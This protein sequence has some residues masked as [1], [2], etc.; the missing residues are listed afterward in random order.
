MSATGY[1]DACGFNPVSG[2]T[3]DFVVSAAI[4]GYQTPASAGAVNST[5]YSY[6][7]QSS[8]LSQW[9]NGFGAY[10]TS[11]T[12]LARTTVTASSTGSKV[13]FTSPP[14]VYITA[15]SADLQNASLLASGVVLV[16][17]LPT[18]T[19]ANNIVKLDGSAK[20]PAVDG[21]ALTNIAI[22]GATNIGAYVLAWVVGGSTNMTPG[23]TTAGSNLQLVSQPTGGTGSFLTGTWMCQC[24]TDSTHDTILAKRIA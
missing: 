23:S 5:V 15:L 7:A 9:E 24:K 3:G 6:R 13:S 2:G 17:L 16:S 11:T 4:A 18:G 8:D 14:N 20:L 1:L 12:T 22:P 21:S 19:S 10:T